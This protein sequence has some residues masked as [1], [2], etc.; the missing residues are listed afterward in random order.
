MW[1]IAGLLPDRLTIAAAARLAAHQ[2]LRHGSDEPAQLGPMAAVAGRGELP[3][4]SAYEPGREPQVRL[5]GKRTVRI[6]PRHTAKP[7]KSLDD[8]AFIDVT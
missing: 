2:P 5:V 8:R 1:I 4:T 6:A 3:V 7:P